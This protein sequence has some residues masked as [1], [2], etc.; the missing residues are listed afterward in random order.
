MKNGDL[1][2]KYYGTTAVDTNKSIDTDDY[3]DE[4]GNLITVNGKTLIYI[5]TPVA[6]SVS[7]YL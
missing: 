1:V 7:A 5:C 2:Y 4:H 6:Y 3:I